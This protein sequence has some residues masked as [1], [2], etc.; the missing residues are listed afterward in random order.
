MIYVFCIEIHAL[1][2]YYT[3]SKEILLI[4]QTQINHHG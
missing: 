3:I 2:N 4:L 1:N